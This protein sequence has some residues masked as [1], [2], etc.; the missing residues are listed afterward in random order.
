[1]GKDRRGMLLAYK[2]IK[3]LEEKRNEEPRID[4]KYE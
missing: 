1:M 2:K 4:V 3:Q